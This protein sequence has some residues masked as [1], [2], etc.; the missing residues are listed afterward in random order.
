MVEPNGVV[1]PPREVWERVLGM[2]NS[3]TEIKGLLQ[4]T[5][6][7]T[8]QRHSSME[9]RVEDLSEGHATSRAQ[10]SN[11]DVRLN[12]LEADKESRDKRDARRP[13]W[14]GVIGA[15]SGL[16]ALVLLAQQIL[17]SILK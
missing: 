16:S 9:V 8:E 7:L 4:Q 3:L 2:E 5:I 6:A 13:T 11:H 10:I 14:L 15:G 17:T 1:I 12:L